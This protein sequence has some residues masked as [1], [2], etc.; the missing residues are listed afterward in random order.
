MNENR[1]EDNVLLKERPKLL[2]TAELFM[3]FMNQIH[4]TFNVSLSFYSVPISHIR[5][6]ENEMQR[7]RLFKYDKRCCFS[8]FGF[9]D[10]MRS[11]GLDR[12]LEA[13]IVLNLNAGLPFVMSTQA[14]GFSCS[15]ERH[16]ICIKYLKAGI[17]SD[18]KAG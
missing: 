1:F 7:V 17:K 18:L 3:R 13:L 12:Q 5:F 9:C 11:C 16:P 8:F 4:Y 10:A 6:S 15:L 14:L 2:T